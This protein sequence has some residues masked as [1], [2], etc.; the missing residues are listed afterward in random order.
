M[1]TP[2]SNR[3]SRKVVARI[4]LETRS[5]SVRARNPYVLTSG[6]HSPVYVDCRRLISFPE[7]RRVI[8]NL[9]AE[10]IDRYMGSFHFDVIA[11]GETAGIPYASWIADRLHK[12]MIYIRKKAKEFGHMSRIEGIL[13]PGQNVLLVEDL[14][15]DGQSKFDFVDAIHQ[16]GGNCSHLFVV[17][18][19]DIFPETRG[20]FLEKNLHMHDLCTWADVLQT[21]EQDQLLPS[22][23]LQ[24]VRRFIKDPLGWTPTIPA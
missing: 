15:T 7:A 1:L 9:A 12:P 8:I 22:Q 4:L 17:F 23:T 20:L 10:Q 19:Y 13:S 24:D 3:D 18:F 5:I 14:A 6:R 2:S 11:G 21:A 16:A